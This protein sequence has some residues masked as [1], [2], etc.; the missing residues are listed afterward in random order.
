MLQY[1]ISRNKSH[2]SHQILYPTFFFGVMNRIYQYSQQIMESQNQTVAEN[3]H[4]LGRLT[5]PSL[6]KQ[7]QLQ[8]AAQG[9][10]NSSIS[11][12]ASISPRSMTPDFSGRPVPVFGHIHCQ[13]FHLCHGLLFW[14]WAP[15]TKI[16]P[17][18]IFTLPPSY[19]IKIHWWN[20]SEPALG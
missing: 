6:L 15:R 20:P 16:C 8:H 5:H 14:S 4:H 10:Y 9:H 1:S 19:D 13:S 7:S 12:R 3:V 11:T 18:L 17:C 2:Q